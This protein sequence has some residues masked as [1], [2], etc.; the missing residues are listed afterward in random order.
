MQW[1]SVI[2]GFASRFAGLSSRKSFKSSAVSL[3]RFQVF[4]MGLI[5]ATLTLQLAVQ[6]SEPNLYNTK[7]A[8]EL[9][10]PISSALH[11]PADHHS[12]GLS[13]A[14]NFSH[15]TS[16]QRNRLIKALY[17]NRANRGIKLAHWNAGSAH[18]GNK[19]VEL[20]QVVAGLHPHVLGISE[21]NF[22]KATVW[23]MCR[24]NTMIWFSAAPLKMM[25]SI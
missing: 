4:C 23:K 2:G 21:A 12:N 22:K 13:R 17:G 24:W 1:R 15:L 11:G 3:S 9:Q 16:K 19:M 7:H 5:L 18:L 6:L 14:S 20:Q 10:Q 8:S 25:S